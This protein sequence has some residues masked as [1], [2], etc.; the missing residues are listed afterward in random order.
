MFGFLKRIFCKD[1]VRKVYLCTTEGRER[2]CYEFTAHGDRVAFE[3]IGPFYCKL[4][5]DGLVVIDHA[6]YMS[7][8]GKPYGDWTWR[9]KRPSNVFFKGH[10]GYWK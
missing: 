8:Y 9:D 4:R 6:Q 10:G 2:V 1:R 3:C 7:G 5:E